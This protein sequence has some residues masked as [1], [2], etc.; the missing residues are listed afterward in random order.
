MTDNVVSI[1]TAEASQ[2]H[3]QVSLWLYNT[4]V[5]LVHNRTVCEQQNCIYQ[6][7]LTSVFC[8]CVNVVC[9]SVFS[10]TN[11]SAQ[12][13]EQSKLTLPF[14]V[15]HLSRLA[16]PN[17]PSRPSSPLKVYLEM[18]AQKV[19]MSQSICHSMR[20]GTRKGTCDPGALNRSSFMMMDV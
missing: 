3:S 11:T 16:F 7:W 19:A 20:L 15:R 12:N 18:S 13:E 5:A 4:V 17:H 9:N 8:F 14:S 10:T 1:H 2:T 6:T